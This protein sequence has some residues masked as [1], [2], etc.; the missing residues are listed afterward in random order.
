MIEANIAYT[1]LQEFQRVPFV[2]SRT[3]V[4]PCHH[5]ATRIPVSYLCDFIFGTITF[6]CV[7]SVLRSVKFLTLGP[8]EGRIYNDISIWKDTAYQQTVNLTGKEL[9]DR[10]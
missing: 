5:Y 9:M 1:L 4:D 3:S 7:Y 8:L 2:K 10:T 6:L